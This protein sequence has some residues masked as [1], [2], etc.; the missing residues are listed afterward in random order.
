MAFVHFF[1]DITSGGR[2]GV[3]MLYNSIYRHAAPI[4]WVTYKE[5]CSRALVLKTCQYFQHVRNR[6]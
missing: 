1:Q 6:F 3:I 4:S 2:T 5:S